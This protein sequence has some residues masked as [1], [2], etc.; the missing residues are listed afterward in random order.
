MNNKQEK[1]MDGYWITESTTYKIF[2]ESEE[3]A[4]EVWRKY[5]LEGINSGQLPMKAKSF[6]VEADWQWEEEES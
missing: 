2:A 4:R 1:K 3:Q 5:W 6:D